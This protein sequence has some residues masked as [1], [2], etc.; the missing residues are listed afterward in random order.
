MWHVTESSYTRA[1]IGYKMIKSRLSFWQ[2]L[3]LQH[4]QNCH[5]TILLYL[6]VWLVFVFMKM[7]SHC[8]VSKSLDTVDALVLK[9]CRYSVSCRVLEETDMAY[10]TVSGVVE[11]TAVATANIATA[12]L[13]TALDCCWLWRRKYVWI[14][15]WRNESSCWLA[16]DAKGSNDKWED[17]DRHRNGRDQ[18]IAT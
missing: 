12:V 7:D 3:Y 15:F 9:L 4:Q 5:H 17:K 14:P 2:H 6:M 16:P 13:R 11:G 10:G 1:I 8:R 18:H